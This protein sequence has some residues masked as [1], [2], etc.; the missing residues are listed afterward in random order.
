MTS[1]SGSHPRVC[2]LYAGLVTG[3]MWQLTHDKGHNTSD[4]RKKEEKKP[5]IFL[6]W[7]HYTYTSRDLVC[8]ACK[9]KLYNDGQRIIFFN[10]KSTSI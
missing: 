6:F 5:W 1:A 2:A 4:I 8:Y 10:S 7:C 3:D 9:K